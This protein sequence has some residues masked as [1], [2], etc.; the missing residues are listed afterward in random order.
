MI[1]LFCKY[2]FVYILTLVEVVYNIYKLILTS[3]SKSSFHSWLT[4]VLL[5]I[6]D[7]FLEIF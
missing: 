1:E 4:F 2:Q 3:A 7:G 6:I 5:R